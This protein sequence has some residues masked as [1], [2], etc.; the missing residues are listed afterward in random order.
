MLEYLQ[1]AIEN[2]PQEDKTHWQEQLSLYSLLKINAEPSCFLY[3][4]AG[5]ESFIEN[6]REFR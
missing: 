4:Y 5:F 1:K 6:N 3:S 2:Q